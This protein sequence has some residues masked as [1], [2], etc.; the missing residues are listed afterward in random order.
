MA[1]NSIS[2]VAPNVKSLGGGPELPTTDHAP[3]TVQQW[4]MISFLISEVALFGT[5]IFT[6]VFYLGK[7]VIGPTPA[8]ALSLPLVVITTACLLAS[9]GTIH[10]AEKAL[11]R[12]NRRRFIQ[13][14]L[15]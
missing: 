12:G 14:W 2:V 1:N 11:R 13:L 6:Y 9:S 15:A 5:L 10:F 4:G 3:L 7:D 8:E